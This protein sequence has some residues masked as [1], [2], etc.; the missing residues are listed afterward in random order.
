MQSGFRTQL[1]AVT[2]L[3]FLL[4]G[5]VATAQILTS[6]LSAA[7]G[8]VSKAG[9]LL[10]D[11]RYEGG[12]AYLLYEDRVSTDR[13]L[14]AIRLSRRLAAVLS[15]SSRIVLVP[16]YLQQSVVALPAGETRPSVLRSRSGLVNRKKLRPSWTHTTIDFVIHPQVRW[17]I[18]F[19]QDYLRTNPRIAPEIVIRHGGFVASAQWVLPIDQQIPG[20]GE[21]YNRE[22]HPGI[23]RA[24][25]LA[26]A[27]DNSFLSLDA[28]LFTRNRYGYQLG[29]R[30]YMGRTI[31]GL[32]LGLT[33]YFSYFRGAWQSGRLDT[34]SPMLD[35]IHQLPKWN[36]V[37]RL[38]VGSFLAQDKTV[39]RLGEYLVN[40]WG[41]R[42]DLFRRFGATRFGFF[43]RTN[44]AEYS[45][46][47]TAVIP[48][49]RGRS[50][51]SR[52]VAFSV[53]PQAHFQ[54]DFGR[55]KRG[56]F[57]REERGG[58]WFQTGRRWEFLDQQM[59]PVYWKMMR[60]LD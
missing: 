23:I 9:H 4:F 28:G 15:D 16:T 32:E 13:V 14:E 49:F 8:L 22:H 47:I 53:R 60:A 41:A 51:G 7:K 55:T 34:F 58:R 50:V 40:D 35:L 2:V 20:P 38:R 31:V 45:T 57:S 18:G 1:A 21:L 27:G 43:V 24:G 46:G 29:Y 59:S 17:E 54:W 42:F 26:R 11:T 10:L 37:G 3:V 56:D 12:R 19:F 39:L 5:Q 30:R 52:N 6:D 25:Y 36:M 48:L 33:G 44:E